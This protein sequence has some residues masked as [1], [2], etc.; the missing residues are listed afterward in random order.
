MLIILNELLCALH[1]TTGA[2]YPQ[3][4]RNFSGLSGKLGKTGKAREV[5][6]DPQPYSIAVIL[7]NIISVLHILLIGVIFIMMFMHLRN[8]CRNFLQLKYFWKNFLELSNL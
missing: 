1:Q 6:I 7:E 4:N 3:P 5:A 2:S 8:L